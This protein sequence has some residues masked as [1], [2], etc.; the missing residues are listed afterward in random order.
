MG[1]RRFTDSLDTIA[2]GTTIKPLIRQVVA[3]QSS[4][5]LDDGFEQM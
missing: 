3:L 5:S 4:T 2:H 1:I